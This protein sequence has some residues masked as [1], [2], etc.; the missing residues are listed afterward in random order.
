MGPKDPNEIVISSLSSVIDN[1][2]GSA[3]SLSHEG[4]RF[5]SWFRHLLVL[6]FIHDLIDC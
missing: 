6:L 4:L 2:V 1:S 5:K 3:L